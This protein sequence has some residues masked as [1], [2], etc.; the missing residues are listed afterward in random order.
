MSGRAAEHPGALQYYPWLCGQVLIMA[1]APLQA[2]VAAQIAV[3]PKR[4]SILPDM[5]LKCR[6]P[7]GVALNLAGR[8]AERVLHALWRCVCAESAAWAQKAILLIERSGW[9]Q[10]NGRALTCFHVGLDARHALVWR[11]V[12]DTQW[13]NAVYMRSHV[14]ACSAPHAIWT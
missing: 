13:L 14:G 6:P 3:E 10:A 5:S 4:K 1:P 2:A 12:A 11:H 7:G 9:L 8:K